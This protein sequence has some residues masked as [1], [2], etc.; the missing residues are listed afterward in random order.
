MAGDV[1]TGGCDT[2]A[3][4]VPPPITLGQSEAKGGREMGE[5]VFEIC[6]VIK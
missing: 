4:L 5:F 1:A 3:T 6:I 2:G